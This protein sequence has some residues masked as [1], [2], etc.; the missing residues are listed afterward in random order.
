MSILRGYGDDLLRLVDETGCTTWTTIDAQDTW[1]GVFENLDITL[2]I[3]FWLYISG[4]K[5]THANHVLLVNEVI[6]AVFYPR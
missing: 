2:Q 4:W 1:H 3:T 6:H 5:L